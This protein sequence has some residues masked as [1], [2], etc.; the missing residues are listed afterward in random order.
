MEKWCRLIDGVTRQAEDEFG[1]FD[2]EMLIRRPEPDKWSVAENLDHLKKFN[3]SY[4]PQIEAMVAG[5]YNRPLLSRIPGLSSAMKGM[6]HHF[7]KPDTTRKMGTF[8]LW[9]PENSLQGGDVLRRFK[10]HQEKLK[11]MIHIAVPFMERGAVVHSPATRWIV[12]DLKGAFDM[13]VDHEKR[14]LKQAKRALKSLTTPTET[15]R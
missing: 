6:L 9:E 7:V 15:S 1:R 5:S 3:D 2:P 14:H 11:E 10:E 12:Y 4:L 8:P 13:I